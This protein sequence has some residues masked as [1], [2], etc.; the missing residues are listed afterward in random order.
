MWSVFSDT[1]KMGYPDGLCL[2]SLP[3]YC[4]SEMEAAKDRHFH[5]GSAEYI[6]IKDLNQFK[7]HFLSFFSFSSTLTPT[8]THRRLWLDVK[9][10]T[11]ITDDLVCQE[12][13]RWGGACRSSWIHNS[14]QTELQE[15]STVQ[16]S[17][18][19]AMNSDCHSEV[20]PLRESRRLQFQQTQAP[21]DVDQAET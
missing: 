12:L 16:P 21:G 2:P 9:L 3:C 4:W 20:R 5:F 14:H 15:S 13:E 8:S 19:F 6:P 7:D 18:L 1:R 11:L 10:E 17:S